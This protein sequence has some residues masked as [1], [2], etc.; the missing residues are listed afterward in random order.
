M[1]TRAVLLPFLM[2]LGAAAC[3]AS[4]GPT[5]QLTMQATGLQPLTIAAI[6]AATAALLLTGWCLLSRPAAMRV[7]WS[8]V[9]FLVIFGLLTVTGFYIALIFSYAMNGVAVATVLLY[10]A[11]AIVTLVAAVVYH[12]RLTGARLVAL[13]LAVGGAAL[14]AGLY[15]HELVALNLTGILVGLAA[16]IGN[17][18]YSLLGKRAMGLHPAPTVLV[19]NLGVGAL[20]LLALTA[21][22][23]PGPL[24]DPGRLLPLALIIGSVLTI[25][26]IT[27]FLLALRRLPAGVV[28]IVASAEPVMAISLAWAVLGESLQPV[29][30][31]GALLV[32]A[33]VLLLAVRE[34]GQ[35][36]AGG[37]R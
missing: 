27:L 16:A 9:P 1:V 22:I 35:P 11:P 36:V 4:L 13:G 30:V 26:P 28:S 5:L 29:Q 17:A 15:D 6:R 33:G 25:V 31:V 7:A 34:A 18:L 23:G 12:E 32:V 20:G 14:V 37:E 3:W 24:P 2:V 19:Y 21:F 10:T 8:A